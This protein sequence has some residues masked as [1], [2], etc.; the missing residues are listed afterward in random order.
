MQMGSLWLLVF[1]ARLRFN[2]KIF[3][4]DRSLLWSSAGLHFLYSLLIRAS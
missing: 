3:S 2:L 4:F 1:V